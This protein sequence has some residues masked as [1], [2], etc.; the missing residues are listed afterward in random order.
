MA[1]CSTCVSGFSAAVCMLAFIFD[2]VLF[3]I[4]KSR[5]NSIQGA[6]ASIGIGI[7]LTLAAWI[8]LFFAGCFYG[9]GRCCVSRRPR[10]DRDREAAPREDQYSEQM[11]LDAVKAE[12][13][14]KARQKQGEMGLPAFQEYQPLTKAD[15]ED[16][17]STRLNSSHSGESRMPSSA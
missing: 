7:W 5:I 8:L 15:P 16:R 4:T 12:A 6:S 17:K 9:F 2:L 13:D 14:R 11:R 1:C 10:R 3:F